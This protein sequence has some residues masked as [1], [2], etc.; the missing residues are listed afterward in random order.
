ME[1]EEE[2][3]ERKARRIGMQ[4]IQNQHGKLVVTR[5]SST[6][7]SGSR[8]CLFMSRSLLIS[9]DDAIDGRESGAALKNCASA[10]VQYRHTAEKRT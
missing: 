1:E 4:T 5:R 2:E 10:A 6:S 3:D 7:S 9:L 8:F